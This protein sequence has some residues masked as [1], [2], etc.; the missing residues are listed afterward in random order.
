MARRN[1]TSPLNTESPGT[2]DEIANATYG[3]LYI[4]DGDNKLY[5][6]GCYPGWGAT[7]DARKNCVADKDIAVGDKLTVIGVKSTYKGTPQVNG[8][9]YFSHEKAE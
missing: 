2:V 4:K 6:Y 7:G 1:R 9:I 5:V 8:G 3:N